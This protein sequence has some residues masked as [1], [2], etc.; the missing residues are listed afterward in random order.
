MPWRTTWLQTLGFCGPLLPIIGNKPASC[1]VL[2]PELFP[3]AL[4]E[5][6]DTGTAQG[7]VGKVLRV[8]PRDW[9]QCTV[10]LPHYA[11]G[12]S[13]GSRL[14]LMIETWVNVGGYWGQ[15]TSIS[16]KTG[17][18]QLTDKPKRHDRETPLHR[19]SKASLVSANPGGEGNAQKQMQGTVG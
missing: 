2:W 9:Y 1:D 10:S 12:V 7:T 4:V 5:V 13:T 17:E 19:V 18:R 15:E 3:A 14:W 11:A 16:R 8:F 6:T